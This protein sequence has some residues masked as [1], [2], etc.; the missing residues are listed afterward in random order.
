MT[1]FKVTIDSASELGQHIEKLSPRGRSREIYMLASIGLKFSSVNNIRHDKG[2]S[3]NTGK[4][5]SDANVKKIEKDS[6]LGQALSVDFGDDLLG[7]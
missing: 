1:T 3:E 2:K 7:L 5:T 4:L 6:V